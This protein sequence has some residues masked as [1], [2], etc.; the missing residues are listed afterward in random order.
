MTVY[1]TIYLI[2]FDIQIQLESLSINFQSPILLPNSQ[3]KFVLTLLYLL[4]FSSFE[5]VPANQGLGLVLSF[6]QQPNPSNPVR[7]Q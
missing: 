1:V 3:F 2:W 4:L 6:L 5:T 7:A